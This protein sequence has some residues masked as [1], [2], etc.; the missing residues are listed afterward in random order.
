MA[1]EADHWV[2]EA[3]ADGL[4]HDD[5]RL[6]APAAERNAAPLASV[7][8][9]LLPGQGRLLELASGTG[10][11][12]VFLA[13]RL[14]GLAWLPSDPDPAARASIEAWRQAAGLPNLEPPLPLDATRDGWAEGLPPVSAVLCVNMIHIAPW[15]ACLGLLAGAARL[16]P[17]GGP[18]ILYG[19]FRRVGVPT[20][21]SNESFDRSLRARDPRWGLRKLEAVMAAAAPL[22]LALEALVEMPA[23]N[24]TLALRRRADSARPEKAL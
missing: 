15:S 8:E 1:A 11:H 14:P 10:Q 4:G 18:L 2:F 19:P 17:E 16:L 13:E 22:G 5:G 21:P 24:L 3:P 23:N 12:A 7:L 9:S 6:F 20:A